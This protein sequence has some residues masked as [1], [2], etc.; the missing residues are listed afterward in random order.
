MAYS[1]QEEVDKLK[2]WWKNYGGALLV[3]VVLG[4][5]LL[6]GNKYWQEYREEQRLEAS[7]L[8]AR[9]LDEAQAGKTEAA[10]ASG[11]TLVQEYD[12]TP[13][14]GLAALMLARLALEDGDA[15]AAR[16]RLE[17]A[18]ANATDPPVQHAAR[19]RLGRLHL[20]AGEYEAALAL[21]QAQAPGFEAE[22][23]ELKGDAHVAL[24]QPEAA[25]AA[26]EQALEHLAPQEPAYGLIRMK[27]DDLGR[28]AA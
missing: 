13:Y 26:Y 27:L 15:A 19:L 22:Y 12:G 9:M 6:F 28:A 3:G 20:A 16:A 23:L 7:A 2:E 8:Y 5:A 11:E 14:A 18:V 1:D 24:A 21:V 17:W 25:R 10:R 4:L